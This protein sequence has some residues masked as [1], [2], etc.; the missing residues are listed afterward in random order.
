MF[1][2]YFFCKVILQYVLYE[3]WPQ[4][5]HLVKYKN[6]AISSFIRLQQCY[7][8]FK[9][10]V[11]HTHVTRAKMKSDYSKKCFWQFQSSR[12]FF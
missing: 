12:F 11:M 4:V 7:A 9:N 10:V 6:I 1:I 3:N 5:A 2:F 8:R